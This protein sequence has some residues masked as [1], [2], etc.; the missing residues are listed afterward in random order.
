MGKMVFDLGKGRIK[1]LF[2]FLDIFSLKKKIKKDIPPGAGLKIQIFCGVLRVTVNIFE[3]LRQ[4]Y[5]QH[6]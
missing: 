2:E 6:F 3:A 1:N 4:V 5:K